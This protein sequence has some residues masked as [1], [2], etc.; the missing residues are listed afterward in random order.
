MGAAMIM[1][2]ETRR[3]LTGWARQFSLLLIVYVAL[4]AL[5][6]RE[7][8]TKPGPLRTAL[9][10][11]PIL[12]GLALIGQTVRAYSRCDEYIRLRFLQAAAMAAVAV[13]SFALVYYFLELLGYPWVSMAWISNIVWAIFVLNMVRLLAAGK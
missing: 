5:A 10:L 4:T 7:L 9:I 12:P 2:E 3:V 6:A 8:G 1:R 13:A 11:A